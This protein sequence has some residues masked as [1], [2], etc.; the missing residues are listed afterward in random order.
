INI[1][2]PLTGLEKHGIRLVK[3]LLGQLKEQGKTILLSSHYAEDMEVC[4]EVYEMEEGQLS[5]CNG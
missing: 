2:A 1:D 3:E 4:D 5:C